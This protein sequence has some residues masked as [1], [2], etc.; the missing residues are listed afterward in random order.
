MFRVFVFAIFV[1]FY[2]S[3][4]VG[5]NGQ[6]RQRLIGSIVVGLIHARTITKASAIGLDERQDDYNVGICYP[7]SLFINLVR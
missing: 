5:V 7:G 4:F 1:L 2:L 3:V 6:Q